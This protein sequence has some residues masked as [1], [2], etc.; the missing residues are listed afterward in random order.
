MLSATW[1]TPPQRVS[2]SHTGLS[3]APHGHR[4]GLGTLTVN[5]SVKLGRT[6]EPQ[7]A[8]EYVW[9]HKRGPP[10]QGL[11]VARGQGRGVVAGRELTAPLALA[12]TDANAESKELRAADTKAY[13]MEFNFR[14]A[15]A[16]KA[17]GEAVDGGG[18]GSGGGVGVGV[19]GG[20][21][22]AGAVQGQGQVQAQAQVQVPLPLETSAAERGRGRDPALN[23]LPGDRKAQQ[24]H[25]NPGC[26]HSRGQ[27][28]IEP[29]CQNTS[30]ADILASTAPTAT[31]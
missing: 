24:A 26:R 31:R 4:L 27:G 3:C 30:D 8:P 19:G 20:G 25:A 18:G 23:M 7:G 2:P 11:R 28:S 9:T 13:A 5:R 21:T 10:E 12:K 15:S 14:R 22:S 6:A 1:A 29:L 16:G 17:G